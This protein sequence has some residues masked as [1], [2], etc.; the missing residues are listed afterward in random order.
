MGHW[1]LKEHLLAVQIDVLAQANW[2]RGG[3]AQAKK[4]T[5]IPRPG[6][7]PTAT[8]GETMARG[9]PV[10][11]EEMNA[12]LGWGAPSPEAIPPRPKRKRDSRGRYTK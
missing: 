7:T 10:S 3:D 8:E 1:D 2:Q 9:K 4:P 6:A 5:P 12:L 11:I